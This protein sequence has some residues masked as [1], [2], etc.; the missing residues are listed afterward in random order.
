MILL[1]LGAGV[2]CSTI[3]SKWNTFFAQYN[4]MNGTEVILTYLILLYKLQIFNIC[5]IFCTQADEIA[6]CIKLHC[7][8]ES[9]QSAT[10]WLSMCC[11]II[12]NGS[13]LIL[14]SV[15]ESRGPQDFKNIFKL[16]KSRCYAST[17]L[18]CWGVNKCLY[19][20]A[21]HH[22]ITQQPYFTTIVKWVV[23][24][25]FFQWICSF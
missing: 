4:A 25:T 5:L 13:I 17:I 15:L 18:P 19:L 1:W 10:A 16:D 20:F 8:V 9:L 12:I 3:C 22:F 7:K 2:N 11:K 24:L 21:T 6:V 14:I 23:I